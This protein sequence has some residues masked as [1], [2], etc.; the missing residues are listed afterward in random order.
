MDLGAAGLSLDR[1]I[2]QYGKLS[3]YALRHNR[4]AYRLQTYLVAVDAEA[5]LVPLGTVSASQADPAALREFLERWLKHRRRAPLRGKVEPSTVEDI[6]SALRILPTA[7]R[8]VAVVERMPVVAQVITIRK[9]R[10]WSFDMSAYRALSHLGIERGRTGGEVATAFM[11][12]SGNTFN[13]GYYTVY[14]TNGKSPRLYMQ[15]GVPPS[16]FV[17]KS[18]L[19]LTFRP[20]SGVDLETIVIPDDSNL[21]EQVRSLVG[22]SRTILRSRASNLTWLDEPAQRWLWDRFKPTLDSPAAPD[23][24]MVE[25][26]LSTAMERWQSAAQWRDWLESLTAFPDWDED[27]DRLFVRGW[28]DEAAAMAV[29]N[30]V[31]I[32]RYIEVSRELTVRGLMRFR[33]SRARLADDF[34]ER[35]VVAHCSRTLRHAKVSHDLEVRLA[36]GRP[37]DIVVGGRNGDVPRPPVATIAC[38][39]RLPTVIGDTPS[40]RG[41]KRRYL[42]AAE[43]RPK[44][45]AQSLLRQGMLRVVTPFGGEDRAAAATVGFNNQGLLSIADMINELRELVG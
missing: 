13:S 32:A 21:A 38:R 29:V 41:V 10:T 17:S 23:W 20:S 18:V 40:L 6:R 33:A 36:T 24:A 1:P 31:A 16:S 11:N 42:L 22:V 25:G 28:N 3:V 37:I 26:A 35:S 2:A 12:D 7:P 15:L 8:K 27:Y 43:A 30:A 39:T 19:V 45:E 5:G 44:P 14:T 4:S 9:R 34:R